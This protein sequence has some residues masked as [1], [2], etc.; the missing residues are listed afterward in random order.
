VKK[1][2]AAMGAVAMFLACAAQPK[3]TSM[4][5]YEE[6]RGTDYARIVEERF[7]DLYKEAQVHHAKATEA[8]RNKEDAA[9]EHHGNVAMVWWVAARTN[10]E[11]VDLEQETANTKKDLE[12]AEARLAAVEK[13]KKDA[14]A[15]VDR[16]EKIIALQGKLGD[17]EGMNKAR[18][19]INEALAAMKQAEAVNARAHA[20]DDF[21][22]A[23]AQFT[24]AT[25]ALEAGKASEAQS[26]AI[27]A[28]QAADA[29]KAASEG[30]YKAE[31]A[32][33]AYQQRRRALFDASAEVPGVQ[34]RITDGGVMITI[35]EV[36]PSGKVEIEPVRYDT[37]NKIAKL[38]Q[39]YDDFSI[40]IEGHTDTKGAASKN[41]QLSESRARSVMSYLTNQGVPPARIT[42]VGKG[43]EQPVA[44]NT[45]QAGRAQNRRIEILFAQGAA[46]K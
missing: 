16:L 22:K 37:F 17:S 18:T 3:S 15:A 29:A 39:E 30:K 10:S 40:V 43:Q 21:G 4:V 8:H 38:A 1:R 44:D 24:V 28:K 34:R 11:I 23:E 41:L 27:Q 13:R 20:P 5:E 19:A 2:I 14:T 42:A 36:F 32:T 46:P 45:T 25:Q 9:M 33:L 12:D 31:Q 7:P 35:R 6:A 26:A